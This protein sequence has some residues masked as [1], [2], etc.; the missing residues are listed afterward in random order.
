MLH[1]KENLLNVTLK[2]EFTLI[3][4]TILSQL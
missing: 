3:N 4:N 2:K 1:Q